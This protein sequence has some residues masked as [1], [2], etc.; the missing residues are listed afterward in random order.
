M[1]NLPHNIIESQW[2]KKKKKKNLT[3]E[4][5]PPPPDFSLF[6]KFKEQ[7]YM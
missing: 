3:D 7:A 5:N 4:N 6:S 1:I 2:G